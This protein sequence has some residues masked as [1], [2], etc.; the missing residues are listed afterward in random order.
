MNI[1]QITDLHVDIS[2]GILLFIGLGA[3]MLFQ[4]VL[5]AV[6][7]GI[8]IMLSYIVHF[9][10]RMARFDPDRRDELAE[11]VESQVEES[12]DEQVES[13]QESVEDTVK[14]TVEETVEEKI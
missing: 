12:I 3:I 10:W 14:E 7:F 4:D 11:T 8:G 6:T 9:A 13:V 2:Y 5:P 1:R